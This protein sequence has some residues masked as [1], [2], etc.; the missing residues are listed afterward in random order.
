M[1]VR[2]FLGGV[3]TSGVILGIGIGLGTAAH[4]AAVVA[5]PAR[6]SGSGSDAGGAPTGSAG[7]KDGLYTGASVRTR[8]GDVQV[9][10]AVAAGRITDLRALHL[11]DRDGRSVQISNRAAPVLR[12]EVISAQSAHVRMVSGATYTSVGYLTSLQSALDQAG[13]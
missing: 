5:A 2:A 1:N 11:T 4:D 7:T 6:V 12:D 8:F 3:M 13:L 10:V 9:Q